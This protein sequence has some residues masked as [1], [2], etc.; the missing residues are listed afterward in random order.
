[1]IKNEREYRITKATLPDSK[2]AWS[3]MTSGSSQ[4]TSIR[5]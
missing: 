1:M 5:A 4:R 3:P 2:A